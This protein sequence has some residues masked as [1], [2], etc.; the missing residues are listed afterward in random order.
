MRKYIEGYPL[1]LAVA[2]GEI[3]FKANF[4]VGNF[5]I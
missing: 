1:L 5:I 3:N 4:I 2:L